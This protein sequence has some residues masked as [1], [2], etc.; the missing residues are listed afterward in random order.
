MQS[1][2]KRNIITS[3]EKFNGCEALGDHDSDDSDSDT[4]SN[5]SNDS[6]ETE[7]RIESLRQPISLQPVIP[8]EES[9][10]SNDEN[11]IPETDPN[12]TNSLFQKI[13]NRMGGRSRMP[14]VDKSTVCHI[15]L[16]YNL[17]GP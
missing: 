10:E 15:F 6:D 7:G 2:M 3:V 8:E 5:Y 13:K 14:S 1:F 9:S 17:N 12:V 11:Q 4:F 16:N